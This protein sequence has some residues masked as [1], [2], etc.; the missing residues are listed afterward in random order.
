MLCYAAC[1]Y[2]RVLWKYALESAMCAHEREMLMYA[3]RICNAVPLS[4]IEK[5]MNATHAYHSTD[6]SSDIVTLVLPLYSHLFRMWTA[7]CRVSGLKSHVES[8]GAS[9]LRVLEDV[10]AM[11]GK[12]SQVSDTAAAVVVV[13]RCT[14]VWLS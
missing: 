8:G 5:T 7:R 4:Q 11:I 14:D 12:L 13:H 10:K 2:I 1:I 3:L 9:S 6:G